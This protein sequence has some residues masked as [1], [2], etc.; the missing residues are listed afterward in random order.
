LREGSRGLQ[1]EKTGFLKE[2]ADLPSKL[3]S[4]RKNK[5]PH[6]RGGKEGTPETEGVNIWNLK[7]NFEQSRG[8][9]RVQQN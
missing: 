6:E 7:H 2:N 5:S 8:Q 3:V 9:G 4:P 1:R